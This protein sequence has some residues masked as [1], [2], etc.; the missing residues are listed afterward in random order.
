MN[1]LERRKFQRTHV[2]VRARIVL[3]DSSIIDCTVLDL[4]I[5]GAGILATP[6]T[7]ISN[8]FDL[9]FDGAR[10]LRP[11]RLIWR[12]SDRMGVEFLQAS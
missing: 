9:T 4:T 8:R 1:M 6:M 10:S 11:C 3:E 2:M 12:T 7:G 5:A